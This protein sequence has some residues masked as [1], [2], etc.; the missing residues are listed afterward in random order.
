MEVKFVIDDIVVIRGGGDLATGIIHKLHRS[1][2]K[3]LVLEIHR[4]LVIRRTV[5]FA[6]A[7]F[8]GE[9]IVEDVKA[10]RVD[11]VE[12]IYKEWEKDNIPVIIDPQ[13]NILSGIKANVLIDAIIAKKNIGT[14]KN[15]APITI[16]LGP[17]FNAGIDVDVVIETVRGHDL[18]KLIF[19]GYAEPNTGIPGIINGYGLERVIKSPA[20]GII[21]NIASIGDSVKK[22]EVISLIGDV[23]V[24]AAIDGILRGLIMDG[25][26]V[27]KGL[28]IADVDPRGKKEHCYTISDKARAI[29]GGVLEAILYMKRVKSL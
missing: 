19:E 23:P 12:G 25:I 1:G 27:Q 3:V 13:C 20:D 2:F 8:S 29:A 5:A 4:P 10:V 9:T 26:E 22:D 14:N 16:A 17:G 11:G 24:T 15:M 6:Q 7:I 21:N 18:G 28:K